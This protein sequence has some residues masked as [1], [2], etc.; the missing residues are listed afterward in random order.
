M[1]Q[2]DN[3]ECT[4]T[5]STNTPTGM[6]YTSTE[7]SDKGGSANGNC[8]NGFGVC[9]VF[10]STTLGATLDQ[11]ISYIQNPG[12]PTTYM[13]AAATNGVYNIRPCNNSKYLKPC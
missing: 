13:P 1:V 5:Q 3:L 6:C 10:A 4:P 7:C 8:A 9:C 11:N 12:F 2:F